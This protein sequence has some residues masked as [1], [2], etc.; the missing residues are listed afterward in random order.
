MVEQLSF[1]GTIEVTAAGEVEV[2]P[3]QAVISLTVITQAKTA[4]EAAACN[5]ERTRA[6]IDAVSALPI[7]G[8]TTVGVG[9]NPITAYDPESDA[10]EIVGFRATNGVTVVTKPADAGRIYDAGVQAGA[11]QSSGISFRLADERPH[12][13]AALRMAIERAH[14][15]A[16]V[17]AEAAGIN[18]LGP[19]TIHIDPGVEPLVY[20]AAA[21]GADTPASP[22]LPDDVPIAASVR[23]VYRTRV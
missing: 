14:A 16:R 1:D 13:E 12:R 11:N 19:Q 10:S 21:L 23:V 2:A 15:D 6:V 5:A 3:D 8:L 9:I 4:A 7:D 17:V 20:R 18:L 22:M